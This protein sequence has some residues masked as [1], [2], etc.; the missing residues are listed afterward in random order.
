LPEKKKQLKYWEKVYLG[1][2]KEQDKQEDLVPTLFYKPVKAEVKNSVR[3]Q[4]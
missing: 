1:K 3:Q 4:V 2:I